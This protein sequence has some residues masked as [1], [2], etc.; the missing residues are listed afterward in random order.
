MANYTFNVYRFKGMRDQL[1]VNS[2]WSLLSGLEYQS[3]RSGKNSFIDWEDNHDAI[4]AYVSESGDSVS[5]N[6]ITGQISGDG[7]SARFVGT[8]I[9][10]PLQETYYKISQLPGYT[11]S[12]ES[13][14]LDSSSLY[15]LTFDESTEE[16]PTI[17]SV[18]DIVKRIEIAN[19]KNTSI[20]A[21][22]VSS[23]L[24]AFE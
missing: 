6:V 2:R 12:E 21:T 14:M 16:R 18:D 10:G 23:R 11:S 7:L 5:Y 4:E 17:E 19:I 20:S 22:S 9:D 15:H 1:E 3:D 24:S 13:F 8:E